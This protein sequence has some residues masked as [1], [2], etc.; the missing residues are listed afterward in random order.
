MQCR[1][2]RAT[3]ENSALSYVGSRFTRT[4]LL[5]LHRCAEKDEEKARVNKCCEE[6]EN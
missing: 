6:R 4:L 1:G 3:V 2:L 5:L